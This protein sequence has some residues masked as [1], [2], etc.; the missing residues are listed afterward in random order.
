[1]PVS[2]TAFAMLRQAYGLSRLESL[3]GMPYVLRGKLA[4]GAMG[5]VRF[6]DSGTLD[7]PK[8]ASTAW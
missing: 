1:M 8:G 2:I 7:L 4:G 3:Q 5:T 6:S